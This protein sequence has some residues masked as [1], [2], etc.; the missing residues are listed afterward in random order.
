MLKKQVRA[1]VDVEVAEPTN[2]RACTRAV[3][4]VRDPCRRENEDF[5]RHGD[6]TVYGKLGIK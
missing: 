5:L 3:N 2:F 4:T 1:L 6:G